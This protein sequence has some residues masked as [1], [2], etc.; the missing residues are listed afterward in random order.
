MSW[1]STHCCPQ[2]WRAKKNSNST[3]CI[4]FYSGFSDHWQIKPLQSIGQAAE[5]KF[6]SKFK[7]VPVQVQA[8]WQ[9]IAIWQLLPKANPEDNWRFWLQN[10][11]PSFW[12]RSLAQLGRVGRAST[13]TGR[14]RGKSSRCG[15]RHAKAWKR[16]LAWFWINSNQNLLPNR[17]QMKYDVWKPCV[18]RTGFDFPF[19]DFLTIHLCK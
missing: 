18:D 6:E 15:H 1:G 11:W 12:G 16:C 7:P 3:Q 19:E 14:F 17:S 9:L 8:I 10:Q 2:F 5:F 4:E 13:N